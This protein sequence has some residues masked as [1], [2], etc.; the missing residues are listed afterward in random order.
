MSASTDFAWLGINRGRVVFHEIFVLKRFTIVYGIFPCDV[1][2]ESFVFYFV[3][4][5][6]YCVRA[7]FSPSFSKMSIENRL[8]WL[9][10]KKTKLPVLISFDDFSCIISIDNE[11]NSE[12][13]KFTNIIG[14]HRMRGKIKEKMK[15]LSPHLIAPGR[16]FFCRKIAE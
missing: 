9:K 14:C 1:N 5:L 2:V 4:A 13:I 15:K 11:Q 12:T 8:T 16:D 6:F 10:D 3:F 7:N